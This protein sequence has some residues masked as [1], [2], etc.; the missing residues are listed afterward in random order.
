MNIKHVRQKGKIELTTSFLL[1]IFARSISR[2]KTST[3]PWNWRCQTQTDLILAVTTYTVS[4]KCML[5]WRLWYGTSFS[6]KKEA[7]GIAQKVGPLAPPQYYYIED[8]EVKTQRNGSDT[9]M[10]KVNKECFCNAVF[11]TEDRRKNDNMLKCGH[12]KK[13]T[14]FAKYSESYPSLLVEKYWVFQNSWK[15]LDGHFGNKCS[16]DF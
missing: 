1:A 9:S 14:E 7:K 10:G 13:G 16:S 8:K 5:L 11:M 3:F 15:F 6:Q 4:S 2:G 12:Y